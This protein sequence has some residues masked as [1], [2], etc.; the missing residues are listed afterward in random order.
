MRDTS[1]IGNLQAILKTLVVDCQL[2]MQQV[3]V[4]RLPAN[5]RA[6]YS[7]RLWTSGQAELRGSPVQLK[8]ALLAQIEDIANL[9]SI[10]LEH[11]GGSVPD[12]G[13]AG[14]A[15][16]EMQTAIIMNGSGHAAQPSPTRNWVSW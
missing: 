16:S 1:D 4:D 5:D 14:N 12:L 2:L 6:D 13:Q 11:T 7:R 10:L 8:R 9:K 3:D 15:A